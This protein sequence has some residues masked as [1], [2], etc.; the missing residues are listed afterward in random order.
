MLGSCYFFVSDLAHR[1]RHDK[2]GVTAIE[3]GLIAGAISVAIIATVLLI[4]TDLN[5]L[6]TTIQTDQKS[7]N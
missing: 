2:S 5:N 1:L 7:A 3:Y 6:F 4:G